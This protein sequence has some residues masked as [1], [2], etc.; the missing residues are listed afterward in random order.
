MLRSGVVGNLSIICSKEVFC[1]FLSDTF[2]VRRGLGLM[3][4]LLR[5]LLRGLLPVGEGGMGGDGGRTT[6]LMGT[7]SSSEDDASEDDDPADD[8]S[9][10]DDS[11]DDDPEDDD[12]EDDDSS[13]SRSGDSFSS[14]DCCNAGI[15]TEESGTGEGGAG[16]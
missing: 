10:D 6:R 13:N 12:S 5:G 16:G 14:G 7:S 4:E 11:E 2:M 3:R 1:K 15:T 9:E 8:D